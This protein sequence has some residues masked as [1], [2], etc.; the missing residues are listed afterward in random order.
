MDFPISTLSR[1]KGNCY[2]KNVVSKIVACGGLGWGKLHFYFVSQQ[3]K[4]FPE[5][6]MCFKKISPAAGL[7]FSSAV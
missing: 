2:R 6:K 7:D 3:R 5:K 1:S 4:L